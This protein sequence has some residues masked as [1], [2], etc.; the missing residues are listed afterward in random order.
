MPVTVHKVLLHGTILIS[1]AILPIGQMS[2]E[3]QEARNKDIKMYREFHTRKI[4]RKATNQD[5]LHRLLLSSDPLLTSLRPTPKKSEIPFSTDVI[6]LPN[7][8]SSSS[9]ISTSSHVCEMEQSDTEKEQ[10][11]AC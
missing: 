6:A 2:E 11:G 9:D 5:L 8:P 1:T 3:A 4:S 7:L 10:P